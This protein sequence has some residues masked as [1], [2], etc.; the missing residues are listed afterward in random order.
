MAV[1]ADAG[2]SVDVCFVWLNAASV[3]IDDL[4]LFMSRVA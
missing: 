1:F 2:E 3:I 4:K